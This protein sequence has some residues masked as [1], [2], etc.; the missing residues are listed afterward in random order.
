MFKQIFSFLALVATAQAFAP[1]SQTGTSYEWIGYERI[2]VNMNMKSIYISY[3]MF[4]SVQFMYIMQQEERES[5]WNNQSI[6]H[7]QSKHYQSI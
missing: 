4:S 1:V 5:R 3:M 6:N 2:E 7:D